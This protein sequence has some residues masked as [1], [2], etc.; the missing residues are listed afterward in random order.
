MTISSV[1]HQ[2]RLKDIKINLKTRYNGQ[3][4]T[5]NTISNSLLLIFR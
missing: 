1:G 4:S 3:E 2:D 5:V